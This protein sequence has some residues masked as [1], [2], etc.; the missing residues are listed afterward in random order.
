[1]EF[2]SKNYNKFFY[3]CVYTGASI[4]LIEGLLEFNLYKKNPYYNIFNNILNWTIDGFLTGLIWPLGVPM[5]L[6][7]IFDFIIEKNKKKFIV[8]KNE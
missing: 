7:S 2:I 6:L 1:M 4:G 8:N 3:C 5:Y